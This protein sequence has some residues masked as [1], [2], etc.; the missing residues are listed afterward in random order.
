MRMTVCLRSKMFEKASASRQL[1]L[2]LAQVVNMKLSPSRSE[3]L[4]KDRSVGLVR[5][6]YSAAPCIINFMGNDLC[7]EIQDKC[8]VNM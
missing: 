6:S 5:S 2:G 4:A 7:L 3:G 1:R 8:G